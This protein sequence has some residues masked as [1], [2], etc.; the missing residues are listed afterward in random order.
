MPGWPNHNPVAPVSA[1]PSTTTAVVLP[2]L[3]PA[4]NMP[5]AKVAAGAAAAGGAVLGGMSFF[6][7]CPKTGGADRTTTASHPIRVAVTCMRFLILECGSLL[8][9]WF[10]WFESNTAP[11]RKQGP[12]DLRQSKTAAQTDITS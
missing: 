9:F 5:V 3:P 6:I 1:P 12:E 11:R 2:G 10:F 4:G 7:A 8:P